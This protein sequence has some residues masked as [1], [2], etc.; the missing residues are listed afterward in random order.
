[1]KNKLL[2]ILITAFGTASAQEPIFLEAATHP[3]SGQFYTRALFSAE[4]YNLAGMDT[5]E[6]NI[7]LKT[8]FGLRPTLAL[9][10]DTEFRRLDAARTDASGFALATVRL[11][12]QFFKRDLG[13]LNTWRASWTGG[14]GL[15]LDDE[16]L[17][18]EN[19]VPRA[20]AVTTAILGRHGLNAQLDWKGYRHEPD[21]VE[22]NASHLYRISPAEYA[23]DTQGA[24][25]TMLES[26]NEISDNGDRRA[27][28]GLGILYEARRWAVEAAL[29]L[30]IHE[31]DSR[32]SDGQITLGWRWLL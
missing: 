1:M 22:L 21:Q 8:A 4:K 26:L 7:L 11:K 28:A 29:R 3:G 17:A 12:Y 32:K 6:Q 9:L 19:P 2:I 18:P 27:D 14:I 20:G 25:Y 5:E 24:W 23:A 16:P 30:P 13:P 31:N 10:I 15:P